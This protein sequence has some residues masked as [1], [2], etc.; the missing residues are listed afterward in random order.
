LAAG[1]N[2]DPKNV[3]TTSVTFLR[4]AVVSGV[5]VKAGDSADVSENEIENLVESKAIEQRDR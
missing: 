4:S 5:A 2:V 3:K 1:G